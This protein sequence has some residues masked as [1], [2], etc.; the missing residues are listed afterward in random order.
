MDN[1]LKGVSD[2]LT[3]A[4]AAG[5]KKFKVITDSEFVDE[6]IKDNRIPAVDVIGLKE[7]KASIKGFDFNKAYRQS[8]D[9]TIIVIQDAKVLRDIIKGT[10]SVWG[11]SRYVWEMIES[12]RTFGGVVRGIEDK[13]VETELIKPVKDNSIKLGIETKLTVTRDVFK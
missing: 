9:I 1:V 12:D 11:L 6:I 13:P 2:F 4:D 10:K 5:S 7:R 8:F 3:A